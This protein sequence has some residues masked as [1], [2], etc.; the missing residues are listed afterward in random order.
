MADQTIKGP[1]PQVHDGSKLRIG[2]IHARWN[3]EVIKAL[4]DGTLA[5]LKKAGVKEE[6]IVLKSVPGSYELPFACQ[7][8]LIE[9]GKTQASGANSLISTTNLLSLVEGEGTGG[10][11]TPA[12][13]KAG[14]ANKQPF[15]AVIAI[16][17]LIKGSTMHFEYI[18]DA[19]SQGLMRVQLDSGTPV[20]FGVL[21]CLNGDQAL[22]RAG[23]GRK[24]NKGHNHGEDWGLAAVEMAKATQEWAKGHI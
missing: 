19:V 24:G 14:A 2:I 4:V 18:C 5:Q 13:D 16:G 15:D 3:D 21:T 12:G 11:S 20:I 17:V 23:I 7:N 10:T 22:E 1:A 8:R 9:G 6:N